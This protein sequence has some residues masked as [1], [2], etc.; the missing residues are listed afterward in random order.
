MLNE[1]PVEENFD[2]KSALLWGG[3]RRPGCCRPFSEALEYD[4]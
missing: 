1:W 2:I 3:E 4:E